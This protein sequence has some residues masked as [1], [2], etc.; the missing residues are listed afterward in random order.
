MGGVGMLDVDNVPKTTR[1]AAQ[2][3]ARGKAHVSVK[4]HNGGTVLNDLHQAGSLKVVFPRTE[5][6]ALQ[7]VTVNTA[8]GITGGDNFKASFEAA[9][10]TTLTVTTQAAERAYAAKDEIGRLSTH[11]RVAA[12]G[13]LNWLP[14]ETILFEASNFE[15]KM[16]VDL[17]EDARLLF[18]EPLV[19]GRTARGE[20]LRDVSFRD[21][22]QINRAGAPLFHDAMHLTGDVTA[23]MKRTANGAGAFASVIYVAPDAESHLQNV[24][25]LLPLQGGAS[26]LQSDVLHIRLLAQDSFVLRQSLIPI[27]RVLNDAQ[28]PRVWMI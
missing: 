14:Q 13:A 21:A 11:L 28:L 4:P 25:A 10:G 26:L 17:E 1:T 9:A 18:V 7:A 23:H 12:G 15:R 27:L 5:G 24:R 6:A 20:V 16:Q 19:F 22:I 3:R 8:G 2:P